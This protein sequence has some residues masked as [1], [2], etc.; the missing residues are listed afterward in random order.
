MAPATNS[1]LPPRPKTSGNLAKLIPMREERRCHATTRNYRSRVVFVA[2]FF[3]KIGAKATP[4]R[5]T[6]NVQPVIIT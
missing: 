6:A 4:P 1:T 5:A 3:N 2:D